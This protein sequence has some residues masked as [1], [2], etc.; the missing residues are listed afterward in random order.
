M[1][2]TAGAGIPT[3]QVLAEVAPGSLPPRRRVE[4]VQV[5]S[6]IYLPVLLK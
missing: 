3:S 1:T 4:L 6:A 2:Y 5:W